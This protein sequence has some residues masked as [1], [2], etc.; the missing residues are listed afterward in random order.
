MF[1]LVGRTSIVASTAN[2]VDRWQLLVSLRETFVELSW[3]YFFCD[4]RR[5]VAKFLRSK[6]STGARYPYFG[7]TRIS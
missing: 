5:A 1:K 6:V 4:D 2:L 7:D 3:Q